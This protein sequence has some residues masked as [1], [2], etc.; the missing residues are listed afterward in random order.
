MVIS[1]ILPTTSHISVGGESGCR[2]IF[3]KILRIDV[4][5]TFKGPARMI[6]IKALANVPS[7]DAL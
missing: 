4:L 3:V 6:R 2:L 7:C 1:N 5:P